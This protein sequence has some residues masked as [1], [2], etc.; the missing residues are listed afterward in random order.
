MGRRVLYQFSN[1]EEKSSRLSGKYRVLMYENFC[2]I[3]NNDDFPPYNQFTRE[4]L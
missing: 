1:K 3:L 4:G 2:E